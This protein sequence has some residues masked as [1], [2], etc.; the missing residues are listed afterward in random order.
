MKQ[1]RNCVFETNSSSTHAVSIRHPYYISDSY[2]TIDHN[3]YI[4]THFGEFGWDL[5]SY[6]EQQEKLQYIVTMIA[7]VNHIDCRRW[8]GTMDRIRSEMEDLYEWQKLNDLIIKHCNCKNGLY[9][10]EGSGYIDHQSCN[11]GSIQEFLDEWGCTLEEFIFSPAI[12]LHID[13]DNH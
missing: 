4:H 10:D 9:L 12:T 13:N 5:A 3:G 6:T 11:Y 7:E 8:W 2:L 1:Q